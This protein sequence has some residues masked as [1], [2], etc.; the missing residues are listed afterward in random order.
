VKLELV[1]NREGC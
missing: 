1:W